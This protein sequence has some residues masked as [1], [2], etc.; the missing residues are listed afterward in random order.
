MNWMDNHRQYLI[1]V[2][3]RRFWFYCPADMTRDDA[4]KV[5][6]AVSDALSRDVDNA[7]VEIP[8]GCSLQGMM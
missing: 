4:D 5:V 1:S 7:I 3:G 8:K 2:K 6:R